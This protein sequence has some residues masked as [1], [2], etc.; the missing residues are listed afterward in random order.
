M[1]RKWRMKRIYFARF[2]QRSHNALI[3]V[4]EAGDKKKRKAPRVCPGKL[5]LD[6]SM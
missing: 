1:A 5:E 6:Q 4:E 2:E 3:A